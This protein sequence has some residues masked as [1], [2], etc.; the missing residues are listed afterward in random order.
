MET[1]KALINLVL[2]I[3][4][5]GFTALAIDLRRKYLV[6]KRGRRLE[7]DM[8]IYVK[9]PDS[10]TAK[11]ELLQKIETD[12]FIYLSTKDRLKGFNPFND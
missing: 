2:F 9:L 8:E 3:E 1:G 4:G 11:K 5:V 12:T 7:K 6:H 10:S